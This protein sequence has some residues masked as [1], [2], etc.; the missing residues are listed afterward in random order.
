[1]STTTITA[2]DINKLRQATGAGMMDCRKALT[3]SNGDFDAAID[4]LRKQGQKVAAK[5]QDR[6]AK[7]GVVIAKTTQGG[8]SGFVLCV[9][10]ETDFV[11]KNAEFV[12][13]AQSLIDLAIAKDLK[14]L[15]E[16]NAA[17][18]EG[19][20]VVEKINEQVGK[21]G[22]KIGITRFERIDAAAVAAYIHGANRMGVL[23]GLSKG[24]DAA[25]EAGRD[26]AMQIAAM[27]PVAVDESS[28]P[29]E[30][31][32]R[33]KAIVLE[34]IKQDPKMAGK[35]DE[36]LEKIAAGKL[37]NF[38]KESTLMAQA[39]VKDNSKSVADYLKSVDP[40]LKVT[41]F[42]RVALG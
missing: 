40:A 29:A 38:F 21:I 13:F 10:C 2:A 34:Q 6:E 4:W 26:L 3:E 27:N 30:A 5:R 16:L 41:S 1:M 11:A 18:Y 39:F 15:D 35:P 20:T 42:V 31:I 14:T 19:I 32:E 25:L 12:A 8:A 7:E 23:V 22:E 37:N 28:V 17:P 36:M 24:G 9:A 33:E